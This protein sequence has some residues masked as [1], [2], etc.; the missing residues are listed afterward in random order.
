MRESTDT[1]LIGTLLS[2]D[3][4]HIVRTG[5][6]IADALGARAHLAHAWSY[7]EAYGGGPMG[8][9]WM[10]PELFAGYEKEIGDALAAQIE[11]LG[12]DDGQLDGASLKLG[13]AHQVLTDI[14]RD[15]GAAMIVVGAAHGGLV[16][17]VLGSTADRV[18]RKATCPIFAVRG[19]PRLPP[20][21][22]LA[23]VDLSS[24]SSTALRTGTALL[25]RMSGSSPPTVD[26]LFVLSPIQR[27]IGLQ[28]TPE[29]VDRFVS[30]EL[31]RFVEQ[32]MPAD[33]LKAE[34][35][36]RVG[37]PR[38]EIL[39]EIDATSTDL[40]VIGTHG[41]GGFD[42]LVLGSVAS[43]V[44]RRAPCS[45]LVVPPSEDHTDDRVAEAAVD[46]APHLPDEIRPVLGPRP[47]T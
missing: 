2:E 43:D 10:G 16:E 44:A 19:E 20:I 28:F 36:V 18:I 7:P 45:V 38:D 12:I 40:V 30:E 15:I 47:P 42:R 5:L 27:Q 33:T 25:E 23:P 8:P 14:A 13:T 35:T 22:V 21:R 24:L 41:R 4:D 31:R 6:A 34:T 46:M 1:V 39:A 37:E 26:I 9:G 17:R 29:Q 32:A 11:R 3:S